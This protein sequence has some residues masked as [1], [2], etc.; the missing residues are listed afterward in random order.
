MTELT[1]GRHS[2]MLKKSLV[3][4][5]RMMAE[6]YPGASIEYTALSNAADRL[7]LHDEITLKVNEL[8]RIL[9]ASEA[10]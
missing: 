1:K 7:E 5:L 3:G 9:N 6:D 8:S 4:K 10:R 2:A